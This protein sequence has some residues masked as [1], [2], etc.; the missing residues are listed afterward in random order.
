[1][2]A[3]SKPF[4]DEQN[5]WLVDNLS[6]YSNYAELTEAYNEHFGTNYKWSRRGYSPIERRCTRMG[7]RRYENAYGFTKKEDVWL[8]EYAP[9]FSSNWLSK[10][11]PSVDGNKHSA[12]AIKM[13]VREWLDIH[14]GN[15]GVREDT[16]QTYK[17]PLGSLC[18]WG[19]GRTR[20]KIKDTGDDRIDWYPYGRYVYEN[21][22]GIKLPNNVQIIHLDG[23]R[24]NF[25]INNLCPVTHREHAILTANDWHSSGEIT[26]CGATWAKLSLLVKDDGEGT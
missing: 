12:E 1:M 14:K 19:T 23:D 22:Y 5:Q 9:R 26:R 4:T 24:T 13:H 11:I 2:I 17:R 7:L 20:I 16:I 15:G 10:N 3:M 18:S 6:K 21:H 8:K 25:D